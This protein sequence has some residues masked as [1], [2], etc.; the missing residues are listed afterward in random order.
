MHVYMYAF[1]YVHTVEKPF[2][3]LVLSNHS[4]TPF[5]SFIE[6]T[7]TSDCEGELWSQKAYLQILTL[8]S[9]VT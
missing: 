9:I 3:L 2:L 5:F 4:P 1:M 6:F 7:T 8:T